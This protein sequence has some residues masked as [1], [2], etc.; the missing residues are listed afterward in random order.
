MKRQLS[1]LTILVLALASGLMFF[2]GTVESQRKK[3][4]AVVTIREETPGPAALSAAPPECT[5][6]VRDFI[7][8][9]SREK[10]DIASDRQAQ[11]RWLSDSLHK[12]LEHRLTVYKEYDKKNPDSPDGPPG[13]GDFVGSWDYPT[14]YVI[15]ASRRYE[16]RAIV[17]VIYTWGPKTEYPGDKRLVSYVLVREGNGWKIEDLYT[18]HGEY[19]AAGSLNQTFFSETYP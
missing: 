2:H 19:V 15:A 10:P 17:D 7:G 12:A 8:Y 14:T 3:R 6:I 13:N 18:F 9:V 4:G 16:K 11:N 5:Q 1:L